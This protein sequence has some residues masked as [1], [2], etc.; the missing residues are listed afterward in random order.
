MVCARPSAW[1]HHVVTVDAMVSIPPRYRCWSPRRAN[2]EAM[3]SASGVRRG[4][5]RSASSATTSPFLGQSGDRPGMVIRCWPGPSTGAVAADLRQDALDARSIS[6]RSRHPL[7]WLGFRRSTCRRRCAISSRGRRHLTTSGYLRD[8]ILL[9]LCCAC[10]RFC[11]PGCR[12]A[13]TSPRKQP[14]LEQ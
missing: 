7:A 12:D 9:G 3:V 11:Y 13:G 2:T 5:R 6:T 8:S 10:S 14:K 4:A 1:L